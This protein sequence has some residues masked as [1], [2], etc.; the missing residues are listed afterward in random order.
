MSPPV[1]ITFF[2]HSKTALTIFFTMLG[3][4]KLRK[5]TEPDY[6][7]KIRIIQ[8]SQKCAIFSTKLLIKNF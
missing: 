8:K 4:D 2:A 3:I 1:T 7:K 5:V 6:P